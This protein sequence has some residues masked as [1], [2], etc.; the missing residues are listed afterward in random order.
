M[1]KTTVGKYL[2]K[3]FEEIGL[4]DYFAIPGD[5]NLTLLDELISNK[6]LK[7]IN[8]C[9]ELN[10]GYAA[11][12]YARSHGV[13]ALLV[14]FSVGSLSA[15][16]AVTGAYA[17]DSPIIVV[18]GGPNSNSVMKDQVL[19]HTIVETEGRQEYVRDMFRKVTAHAT[20]VRNLADAPYQIDRAIEIALT[21]K[22]PVYIEIACNLANQ[23]VCEPG[24]FCFDKKGVSDPLS[25]KAALSHVADFLNKSTKPVL[26]AGPRIRSF[27]SMSAF[28][29][30]A[31]RSG[32][33]VACMPNAKSFFPETHPNYIGIY[34]GSVS[35]PGCREVVESC[36]AYLFAGP[37]F[38]D[39]TTVGYSALIQPSKLIEVSQ[40]RVQVQGQSYHGIDLAEFL[41]KLP[42][43]LKKNSTSHAT[44]KQIKGE[45]APAP[46]HLKDP[47][48]TRR[49]FAQ[50]D[51]MLTANTTV[52]AE[53]GDSWFNGMRLHLPKGCR[54]EIQMQYGSIGWSTGAFLG[55]VS[56]P[57]KRDVIALI[58]D[59]SFQMTAQEISTVLRYGYQGIVFLLNNAGYT[60]EVKIHDGPYNL[61]QN[62]EYA[63]LIDVFK[64]DKGKGWGCVVKTEAELIKAIEKAK[65]FKG[66]SF[67]EVILDREDCNKNLLAW[68]TA[69]ANY[70]STPPGN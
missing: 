35:S 48:T 59:G 1:D 55:L 64:G 45:S 34:W 47:L 3:R 70:N 61:I 54:F 11:D 18:S 52:L 38:S 53:T 15:I 17:E 8:C 21:L 36:D 56:A 39:Y 27:S 63:K 33:G 6:K 14:T 19:H 67:I 44:Y 65:K 42:A 41:E 16:N 68:G 62:W 4:K 25:L 60:I 69:V 22:K 28:Q 40:G 31:E 29:K 51:K 46:S 66:L 26:V 30:L 23:L 32:Y 49:L 5:F 9:N 13:S 58:G 7:M 57:E 10:A 2:A 12:G 24:P 43:K 20:I 37:I 50:I